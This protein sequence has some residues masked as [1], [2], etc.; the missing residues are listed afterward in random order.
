MRL[1]KMLQEPLVRRGPWTSKQL[2]I[3]YPYI[4]KIYIGE[5][6]SNEDEGHGH[7]GPWDHSLGIAHAHVCPKDPANGMVCFS[8][9][10]LVYSKEGLASSTLWHEYAHVLEGGEEFE[11]PH[12]NTEFLADFERIQKSGHG[13]R[14][15]KMMRYVGERVASF[16]FDS[17]AD[18]VKFEGEFADFAIIYR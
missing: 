12:I 4:H 10:N 14:W 6:G 3:P 5:C 11:C 13:D 17:W 2:G 7:K 8:S 9:L 18:Y 15:K 16:Y 1:G